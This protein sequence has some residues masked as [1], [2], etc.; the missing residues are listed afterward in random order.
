MKL[1]YEKILIF[2]TYTRY[3]KTREDIKGKKFEYALDKVMNRISNSCKEIEKDYTEKVQD[4]KIE[5]A[6]IDKDKNIITNEHSDYVY[7][8]ENTKKLT[9]S[10]RKLI[11]ER[12]YKEI[13]I[14]PYITTGI[15]PSLDINIIEVFKG[16]VIP[17]DYEIPEPKE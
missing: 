12:N 10:T 17:I 4:R 13:E 11:E 1:T 16:L 3:I 2:S 6:S 14:E 15:I 7:T 9:E 5:Y 8:I